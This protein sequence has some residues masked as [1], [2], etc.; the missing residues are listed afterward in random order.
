MPD[1]H[2][3]PYFFPQYSVYWKLYL[4]KIVRMLYNPLY[5]A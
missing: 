5:F 3:N 1:C 4:L 2:Y